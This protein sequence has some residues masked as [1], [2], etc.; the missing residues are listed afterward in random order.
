M[1]I[2]ILRRLRIKH[3]GINIRHTILMIMVGVMSTVGKA[4]SHVNIF[5]SPCTDIKM[6]EPVYRETEIYIPNVS[7]RFIGFD[8]YSNITDSME[9]DVTAY[10]VNVLINI[11][12]YYKTYPYLNIASIR[13]RK[14]KYDNLR[15]KIINELNIIDW[16]ADTVIIVER[17]MDALIKTRKCTKFVYFESGSVE[18][19]KEYFE[20]YF[21]RWPQLRDSVELFYEI[22]LSWDIID[23]EKMLWYSSGAGADYE[24]I[25]CYRM[26][27]KSG[28]V[29]SRERMNFIEAILWRVKP[30]DVNNLF[31]IR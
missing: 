21:R 27:I 8:I 2:Q 13:K 9:I 12:R 1:R 16:Q 14:R 19:E 7:G 17:D 11:D 23:I 29:V 15:S 30:K 20:D 10:G 25:S 22:I 5:S 28:N 18:S 3:S 31:D 4:E 26:I 24:Y 6:Y